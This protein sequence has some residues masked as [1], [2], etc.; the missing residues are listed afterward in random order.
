MGRSWRKDAIVVACTSTLAGGVGAGVAPEHPEITPAAILPRLN[1]KTLG[2]FSASTIEGGLTTYSPW[3]YDADESTWT[4]S[5]TWFRRCSVNSRCPMWTQCLNGWLVGASSSSSCGAGGASGSQFCSNHVLLPSKGADN[6]SSWFWCD[7]APLTGTTLFE[8]QPSQPLRPARSTTPVSTDA[9]T[10]S[11]STLS[12]TSG[13]P[14]PSSSSSSFSVG[15]IA[16]GV[17]GG[18]LGVALIGAGAFFL[19]N[20]NRKN[21]KIAASVVGGSYAPPP[22]QPYP[23]GMHPASPNMGY[24]TAYQGNESKP[25]GVQEAGVYGQPQPAGYPQ[26]PYNPHVSM[27]GAPPPGLV[28]APGAP[29]TSAGVGAGAGVTLQELASSPVRR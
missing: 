19:W 1:V 29:V 6:P 26:G 9:L 21:K 15:A 11:T 4:S 18:I 13:T 2:W 27:H 14:A 12:R 22:N 7:T 10:T 28:E 3:T 8:Q 20:R 17:V 25:V 5:S 24:A 23:T 16:G